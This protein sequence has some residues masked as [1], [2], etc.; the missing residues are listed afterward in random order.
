MN[1]I[2]LTT[3]LTACMALTST[4]R[5]ATMVGQ[6]TF[7]NGSLSDSTGHFGNLVLQGNA[8][9]V[10]GALDVNGSATSP[11]G[12]ASTP[13]GAGSPLNPGAGGGV[14]VSSK[15]L[16]SWITLQSLSPIVR[17]GSAMTLD[18]VSTDN[19]DGIVFAEKDANNW[20]SGSTNWFRSPNGQFN[21]TAVSTETGT[22]TIMQLAITYQVSG[23]TVTVTGYRNGVLM[24]TYSSGSAAS[25]AAGDQEVIFGTRH[26]SP[27]GANA[28]TVNGGLDALIHEARLY[29]GALTQTEIAALTM[30]PEPSAGMLGILSVALL[31]AR[32]RRRV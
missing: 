25:W 20:M 32:R 1:H 8:T 24:G 4:T 22:G 2:R 7:E 28:Y 3:I 5:A 30:V 19:F 13:G 11:T 26:I 27:P 21:Q 12:W 10:N 9:V 18:S 17:A 14:A 16:V 31:G 23:S 6:W 29:D 15:T